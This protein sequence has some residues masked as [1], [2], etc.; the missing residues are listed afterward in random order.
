MAGCAFPCSSDSETLSPLESMK[1]LLEKDVDFVCFDHFHTL[2]GRDSC[3]LMC[4][5]CGFYD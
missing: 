1:Q 5:F 3:P 2:L 4:V